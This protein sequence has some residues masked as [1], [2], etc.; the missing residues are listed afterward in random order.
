MQRRI[1][2]ER[3]RYNLFYGSE[4][5]TVADSEDSERRD[6]GCVDRGLAGGLDEAWAQEEARRDRSATAMVDKAREETEREAGARARALQRQWAL[7]R[8]SLLSVI[9]EVG[10]QLHVCG[11]AQCGTVYLSMLLN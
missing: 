6:D 9:E 3:L 7:D 5:G 11:H 2:M 4:P 1:A 8:R 10:L